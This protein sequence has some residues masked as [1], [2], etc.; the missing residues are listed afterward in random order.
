[1]LFIKSSPRPYQTFPLCLASFKSSQSSVVTKCWLY[2]FGIF[3]QE[4][5]IF[6]MMII[7]LTSDHYS[8]LRWQVNILSI[9]K[10]DSD[11]NWDKPVLINEPSRYWEPFLVLHPFLNSTHMQTRR[12]QGF[13]CDSV[14]SKNKKSC[15]VYICITQHMLPQNEITIDMHWLSIEGWPLIFD[16][17]YSPQLLIQ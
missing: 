12:R 1:M 2:L 15:C 9:M 10:N 5:F 4:S 8:F 6:C 13:V 14:L 7:T 17:P 3:E 11:E 16:G